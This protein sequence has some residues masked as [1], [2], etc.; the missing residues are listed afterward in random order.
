M[1]L[2]PGI[3]TVMIGGVIANHPYLQSLLNEKFNL[4]ILVPD[5]PQHLVSFGAAVIAHKTWHR[6]NNQIKQENKL[7]NES[8]SR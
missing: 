2:V 8:I 6:E 1:K 4:Q 7:N 5:E 3:P